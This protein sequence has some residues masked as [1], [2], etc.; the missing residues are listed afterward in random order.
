VDLLE[1]E[2]ERIRRI[3]TAF[4]PLPAAEQLLGMRL[5]PAAGTW[6]AFLAVRVQRAVAWLA[7]RKR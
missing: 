7:R 6:R 5:R 2:G 3:L 4:D 1:F